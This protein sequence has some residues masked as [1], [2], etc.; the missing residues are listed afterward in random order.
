M[1][2]RKLSFTDPTY[3]FDIKITMYRH[4]KTKL[5]ILKLS[6]W[7]QSTIWTKTCLEKAW[8]PSKTNYLFDFYSSSNFSQFSFPIQ[9]VSSKARL[10]QKLRWIYAFFFSFFLNDPVAEKNAHGSTEHST[11]F[12]FKTA[13]RPFPLPPPPLPG[14]FLSFFLSSFLKPSWQL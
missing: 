2:P 14:F 4:V 7:S 13:I 5:S 1:D 11:V 12:F 9:G 10:R 3:K 8:V 6:F